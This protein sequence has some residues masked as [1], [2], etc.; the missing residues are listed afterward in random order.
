MYAIENTCA[1]TVTYSDRFY[2]LHRVLDRLIALNIQKIVV[3]D[4]ASHFNTCYKLKE[5]AAK[6]SPKIHILRFE[7]NLGS[8]G[9]YKA[10]IRKAIEFEECDFIWLLDDDN[11]PA[12]DAIESLRKVHKKFLA[13]RNTDFFA[14]LAF[15]P[16]HQ[17]YIA[18]GVRPNH[19]YSRKGSFWGFHLVDT[20]S[21]TWKRIRVRDKKTIISNMPET[22]ALSWASYGGLFFHKNVIRRIG[23]PDESFV[24]YADDIEYTS[25]LTR[26]GG[27]IFLVPSARIYDIETSWNVK[28]RFNYAFNGWILGGDELRVFYAARNHTYVDCKLWGKSNIWFNINMQLYLLILLLSALRF[29]RIN[30]FKLIRRAVN[31]GLRGKLGKS[32]EHIL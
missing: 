2:L 22:V 6:Y 17:P 4:N 21:K 1:V 28:T 27:E 3:V 7:Q 10:G 26:S 24:L 5:Y 15:R 14:L 18:T 9:G 23:F 30:R 19:G 31:E 25:R 20:P 13:Q 29:K 11:L 16:D 12:H 32:H 8:A